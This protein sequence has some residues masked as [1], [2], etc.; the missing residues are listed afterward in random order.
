MEE[1]CGPLTWYV[2]EDQWKEYAREGAL[3]LRQGSSVN[4]AEAR[5]RAFREAWDQGL[6][7]CQV[8]DDMRWAKQKN[9]ET[10]D[11]VRITGS[12]AIARVLKRLNQ[13]DFKLGG[14]LPTNNPYFAR[15]PITTRT[16]VRSH[17][18]IVKPCDLLLDEHMRVKF[19]YDYTLN[20]IF[21]FGG[22][23]RVDEIIC[24]FDYNSLTGGHVQ[25]DRMRQQEEAI[26][27]LQER[28]G[29]R[30][31]RRNP[32][33]PGEILIRPPQSRRTIL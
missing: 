31:V 6:P 12:E 21:Q 26:L 15:S 33:R 14:C 10:G 25:E 29:D 27:T 17:L 22:V 18:W 32:K 30:V 9:F 7:C 13:T 16:F 28:W 5:N 1:L 4:A 3:D 20:H 19:D 8:D 23:C 24:D 2:P 11:V